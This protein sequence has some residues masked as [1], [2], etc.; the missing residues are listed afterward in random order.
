MIS[1]GEEI[2]AEVRILEM[3]EKKFRLESMGTWNYKYEKEK[4][5]WNNPYYY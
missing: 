2:G 1:I 5:Q 4:Q 3:D